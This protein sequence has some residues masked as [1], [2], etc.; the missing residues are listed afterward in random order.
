MA[1]L[2][3]LSIVKGFFFFF[4]FFFFF[5]NFGKG[6][7]LIGIISDINPEFGKF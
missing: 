4:F 5:L 7:F 2:S 6:P 1:M 3:C